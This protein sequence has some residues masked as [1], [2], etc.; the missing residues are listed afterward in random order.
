MTFQ[1]IQIQCEWK[2][3]DSL[4]RAVLLAPIVTSQNLTAWQLASVIAHLPTFFPDPLVGG[5][6]IG[7]SIVTTIIPCGA[8]FSEVFCYP[9]FY[10]NSKLNSFRNSPYKTY[11]ALHWMFV[12]CFDTFY[13]FPLK[14]KILHQVKDL[15]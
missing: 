5:V 10:C 11:I 12:C 3:L 8:A 4:Y 15:C 9:Q 14:R 2:Y 13:E 6:D 7:S 1:L